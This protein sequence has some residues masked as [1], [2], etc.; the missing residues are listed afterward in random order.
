MNA[1]KQ[2]A[3]INDITLWACRPEKVQRHLPGAKKGIH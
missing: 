3:E 2:D 1:I